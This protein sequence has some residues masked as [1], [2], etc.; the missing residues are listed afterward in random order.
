MAK[1]KVLNFS[2]FHTAIG[3]HV[4]FR[5]VWL[6]FNHLTIR[7]SIVLFL[8]KLLKLNYTVV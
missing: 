4:R 1:K 6:Q 3:K 8:T 2:I 7:T 5:E